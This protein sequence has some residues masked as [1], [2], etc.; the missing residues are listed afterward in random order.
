MTGW[1][2]MY[3]T[4]IHIGF[5]GLRILPAFFSKSKGVAIKA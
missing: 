5:Q 1:F 3:S 4:K 2:D